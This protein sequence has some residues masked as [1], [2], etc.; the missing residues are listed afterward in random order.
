MSWDV[1]FS[2]ELAVEVCALRKSVRRELLARARLLEAVGP[3]LGRPH[4]DTLNG[5]RYGNMKELRFGAD[6]GAWRVAFAFDPERRAVLLV[7]GDKRGSNEKRFY[8]RLIAV[9]DER[10]ADHLR[11]K[12]R[13]P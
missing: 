10:Y 12:E 3:W 7:A 5:S 2:R 8:R 6:R 1:V 11:R 13:M 9:A 4:A